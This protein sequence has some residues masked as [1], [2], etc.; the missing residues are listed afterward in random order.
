VKPLARSA[1]LLGNEGPGL[2][3]SIIAIC[4]RKV[5]IPMK[6]NTDSLNVVVA[7]GIFLNH[8]AGAV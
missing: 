2:E 4:D 8:F 6:L 3:R 1:L 5:T 7:G